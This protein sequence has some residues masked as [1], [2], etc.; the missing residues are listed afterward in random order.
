MTKYRFIT[1]F[2]IWRIFVP[3]I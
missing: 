1:V 2:F 3:Q